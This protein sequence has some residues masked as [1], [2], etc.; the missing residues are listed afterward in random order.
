MTITKIYSERKMELVQLHYF[1]TVALCNNLSQAAEELHVSQPALSVAVKKLEEELGVQLFERRKNK[2]L[3]NEAGRRALK[4]AETVL[5]AAAEMKNAFNA[6]NLLLSLGFCDP[7]PMRFSVPLFQRDNPDINVTS[8]IFADENSLADLLL[9]RKYDAVI[10]LQKSE[11]PALKTIPFA[12]ETLMLSVPENHPWAQKKEICLHAEKDV[13][14]AVY[15]GSGAYVR[16]LKPLLDWLAD[17]H[18]VKIY[19]DYFVFRQLLEQKPIAT[20]TTRLVRQYR[21]D[22]DNRI[23]VPLT[24]SGITAVYWLSYLPGNTRK[25]RP[26]LDWLKKNSAGFLNAEA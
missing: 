9:S 23:I 18:A 15:C 14:L 26:L 4:L 22:G 2:V 8:E 7:G 17:R 16:Q 20:F 24:D 19:D 10:S 25:L 3:L 13:E 12:R 1:K 11:N 6:E 5:S 21:H